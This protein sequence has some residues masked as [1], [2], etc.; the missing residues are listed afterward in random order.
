[1]ERCAASDLGQWSHILRTMNIME[2]VAH[3]RPAAYVSKRKT[4]GMKLPK[5]TRKHL[6]SKLM[7]RSLAIVSDPNGRGLGGPPMFV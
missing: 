3:G 4:V 6:S 5:K 1:M 2:R 7:S